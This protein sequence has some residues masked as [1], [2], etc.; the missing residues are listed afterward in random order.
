MINRILAVL[1]LTSLAMLT[2]AAQCADTPRAVTSPDRSVTFRRFMS[3]ENL[4]PAI[5][6]QDD[7]V[8]Q[9]AEQHALYIVQRHQE[10][11]APQDR[12]GI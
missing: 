6:R 5:R 12:A 2:L 4:K 7:V 1:A 11:E 3:P 9:Y 10:E 8:D